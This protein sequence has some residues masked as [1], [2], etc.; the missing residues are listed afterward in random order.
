[1]ENSK[2]IVHFGS[3]E[4]TNKG[5]WNAVCHANQHSEEKDAPKSTW[6]N[7]KINL[8]MKLK[9]TYIVYPILY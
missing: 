1:M 2:K 9:Y 4:Y 8:S 7:L 3:P 6:Q 5:I